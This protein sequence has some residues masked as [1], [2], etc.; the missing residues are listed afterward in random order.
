MKILLAIDDSECSE[1][2]LQ[3]VLAQFDPKSSEVLV[4]H[5]LDLFVRYAGLAPVDPSALEKILEEE[6]KAAERLLRR[7]EQ[8]L[9]AAG[10]KATSQTQ[11]GDARRVI[12][13]EAT[14]WN[15]D[16]IV[17][18]SH[19]RGALERLLIGSVSEAVLRHAGCSVQIVRARRD[20]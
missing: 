12:L 10:F 13:D 6:R 11:K 14:R 16:L 18:G 1:K 3:T 7:A 4:V 9:E 17:V 15:P 2:A 5:A 20:R 19:G 8:A